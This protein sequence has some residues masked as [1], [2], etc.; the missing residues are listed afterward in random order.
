MVSRKL[1]EVQQSRDENNEEH[2]SGSD[3]WSD[4]GSYDTIEDISFAT[5]C[6]MELGPSL[7]QNLQH[8]ETAQNQSSHLT[9]VPFTMSDPAMIYVSLV[10]EK[11]K[12]AHY[13]LVERLG[14]ANWQRHRD[15]RDKIEYNKLPPEERT[16]VGEETSILHCRFRPYRDF[17]DSS[18]G[19]SA[20]A[21]TDYT[22]SHASFLS[23]NTEG[24][25]ASLRVPKQPSEVG[26]GKPFQC[27]L[28]KCV[29]LNVRNRLDWK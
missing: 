16:K 3:R 6:L 2:D 8:A 27:S 10:R 21:Q 4:S 9:S 29:I 26:V 18:I 20:L 7:E 17:H 19:A 22:P 5:T 13:K 25:H 28:C 12:Q 15:V 11:F 24:E 14:E 23:S 1:D